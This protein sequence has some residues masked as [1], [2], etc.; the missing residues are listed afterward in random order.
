LLPVTYS[1]RGMRLALLQG[2]SFEA[3]GLDIV[4]LIVFS[5][6]SYR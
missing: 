4:A 1:L 6:V 3:F 5:V 2:Y